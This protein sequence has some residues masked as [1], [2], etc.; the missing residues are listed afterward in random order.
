M[1]RVYRGLKESL[2]LCA[3]V[4][5]VTGALLYCAAPV[6][7]PWFSN[8]AAVISQGIII[9]RFFTRLYILWVCVEVFSGVLRGMGDTLVPTLITVVGVCVLRILWCV[10]MVPRKPDIVT[11]SWSYPVTWVIASVA[12]ILYFFL[13]KTKRG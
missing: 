1:K 12:F 7:L 9:E 5:I 3:A 6:I 2:V 13:R 8:D 11:V 10:I 4:S